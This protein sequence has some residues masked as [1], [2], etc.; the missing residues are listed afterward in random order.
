MF[1]GFFPH[2]LLFTLTMLA[3]WTIVL[4]YWGAYQI[5]EHIEVFKIQDMKTQL[6]IHRKL[7]INKCLALLNK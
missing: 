1:A 2:R 3:I 5:H 7:N 6:K 4:L